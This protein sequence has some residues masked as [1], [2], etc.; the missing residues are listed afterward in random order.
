M[1][2]TLSRAALPTPPE[3]SPVASLSALGLRI[4]HARM[5]NGLTL[6]A[7]AQAAQCSESLLSRV[8]RSQAMPSLNT[9]HR[10]AAALQ[11][12][13]A[14]LTLAE[15]PNVQPVMRQ[16]ERPVVQLP[17]ASSKLPGIH[18]ERVIMPVRGQLMQADIH[19]LEPGARADSIS[20]AGE[21]VGYVIEGQLALRIGEDE[22]TLG[23]G[24]TFYFTSD[25]PHSYG[26]PGSS[27]TRILWVNTPATF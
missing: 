9:L 26:N 13:V 10:L 25:T 19:V 27:L 15:A 3:P 8:E 14:E 5:V 12:N 23:P 17:G 2:K 1:R 22:H 24:D 11:T 16:G 20:H 21:E 4:K 18:L 6:K 7:L